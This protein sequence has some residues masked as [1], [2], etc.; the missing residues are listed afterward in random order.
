MTSRECVNTGDVLKHINCNSTIPQD[1]QATFR[2]KY[3][4]EDD[5]VIVKNLY[6]D[7]MSGD[8]VII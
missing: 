6:K 8:L 2:V 7:Y 4:D 1:R 5:G 3:D